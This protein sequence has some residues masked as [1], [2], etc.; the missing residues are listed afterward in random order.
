MYTSPQP[1]RMEPARHV[2]AERYGPQLARRI[3]EAAARNAGL[4]EPHPVQDDDRL[5]ADALA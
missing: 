2:L 5:A 3:L 1:H 4:A